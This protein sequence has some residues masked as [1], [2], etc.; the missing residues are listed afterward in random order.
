MKIADHVNS[1]FADALSGNFDSAMLHACVAI[2]ATSKLRYP[3]VKKVGKRF[4]QTIRD[5]YWLVEA[6]IGAGMD[7]SQMVYS[8]VKLEKNSAP[9]FA[10]IMYEVFRCGYV[11]GDE[12]PEKFSII[13]TTGTWSSATIYGENEVHFPDRIVW[14]LISISVFAKVNERQKLNPVGP[15]GLRLGDT[16]FHVE[17][18]WGREDEVRPFA[19]EHTKFKISKEEMQRLVTV[20][21]DEPTTFSV[22]VQ[23]NVPTHELERAEKEW[24]FRLPRRETPAQ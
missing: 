20:S 8:N 6:M 3:T 7:L 2:D 24:G 11:H 1:C 18:W 4:T 13:P 10:D 19:K 17:D 22:A 16:G 15:Y 21:P 14:A 9:D 23:P 12:V 5:Y